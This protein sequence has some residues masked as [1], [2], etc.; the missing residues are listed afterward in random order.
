MVAGAQSPASPRC[1]GAARDPAGR[2]AEHRVGGIEGK[3]IGPELRADRGHQLLQQAG[4]IPVLAG[5][6]GVR[7]GH[8]LSSFSSKT[9]AAMLTATPP[10]TPR[11][12]R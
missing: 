3:L 10:R 7:A 5:S 6:G 12:C 1:P 4:R 9:V 11:A 8:R 2:A